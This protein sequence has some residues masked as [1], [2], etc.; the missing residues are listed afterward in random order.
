MS[1]ANYDKSNQYF[2]DMNPI[3]VI[4]ECHHLD[5]CMACKSKIKIVER[6]HICGCKTDGFIMIDQGWR[7]GEPWKAWLCHGDYVRI[8]KRLGYE[9]QREEQQQQC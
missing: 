5:Y 7:D 2:A 8:Y 4:A 6:C 3:N 9:W 1:V